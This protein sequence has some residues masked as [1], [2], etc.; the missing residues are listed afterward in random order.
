MFCLLQKPHRK[1]DG[2]WSRNNPHQIIETNDRNGQKVMIFVAI[3]DGDIPIVHPFIDE[4]GRLVSVN[5]PCYLKLLQ[6]IIWSKF[7]FSAT[8]RS[9]WWMQDGAPPH[10]TTAAKEFLLEKFRGRVISRGTEIIWPAHSPDLNPLDFN[11]WAAAQK[12]VYTKK[13]ETIEALVE[14]VRHFA[15]AYDPDAIRRLANNVLKR[16]ELCQRVGGGHFQ[17]LL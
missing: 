3:T 17:H 5:G 8:R 11:F 13:P 10:C 7:R 2:E 16:A 12:E 4:E 1:N 14:C 6:D 15:A 9:L